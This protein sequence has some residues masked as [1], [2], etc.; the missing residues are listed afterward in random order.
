MNLFIVYFSLVT[1]TLCDFL[2]VQWQ[3]ICDRKAPFTHLLF[4]MNVLDQDSAST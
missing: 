1:V 4:R 2:T 3:L